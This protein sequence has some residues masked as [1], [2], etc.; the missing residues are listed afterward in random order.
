MRQVAYRPKRHIYIVESARG[1]AALYVM[2]THVAEM[3]YLPTLYPADSHITIAIDLVMIYGTQAVLL[4]F[5]LSGF[6]IHYASADRD[7][8]QK[9]GLINYYY[10][11]WRRIY[12]VFLVAL[13]F[14]YSADI[15]GYCPFTQD[16]SEYIKDFDLARILYTLGF[17]T[18]RPYM[19][20]LISPVL[21][22][23][24]PLWS[25]SYEVIYYL[26]YPAY[27]YVNRRW[28]FINAAG[29]GFLV[30]L[31]AFALGKVFGHH[32]FFNVLNLYI[33]W[34]LG[35]VL[36]EMHRG[37]IQFRLPMVLHTSAI[38]ILLQTAWV[39]ENATY[40]IG[41]IFEM[42]WGIFFFLV[43]LLFLRS[44]KIEDLSVQHRLYAVIIA[45]VGYLTIIVA[46]RE[47]NFIPNLLLFY[48]HISITLM[49][50]VIGL[51]IPRLNIANLCKQLLKPLYSYGKS[52][53]GIY[54]LHYPILLT[55]FG[56]LHQYDLPPYLGI[57][58]V[59]LILYLGHLVE[60]KFQP[61]A[62]RHLDVQARK[63]GLISSHKR[64][65]RQV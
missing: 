41:A 20:G 32:H 23:N 37:Q 42:T 43:M 51:S 65:Q 1:F 16:H 48:C 40:T 2:L 15:L 22:G 56:I 46:A 52:S 61:M 39:L 17:L 11:R 29:A 7:L 14:G 6:S 33:S 64:W 30:S 24:A 27:W 58:C 10:F 63:L 50:F 44:D 59:P 31:S 35:A 25:L 54:V 55:A 3:L 8:S 19:T 4:F 34:C 57:F 47:L 13:F 9:S 45:T 5:V 60:L 38:Y 12:P 53:Y 36:A 62:A 49:G 26:I 18:D 21:H 28:G